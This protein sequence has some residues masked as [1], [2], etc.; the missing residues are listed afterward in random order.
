MWRAG[1]L[2]GELVVGRVVSWLRAFYCCCARVR[3]CV[4][5][6]LL[7]YLPACLLP[8]LRRCPLAC[9]PLNSLPESLSK[10]R[11]RIC[12]RERGAGGKR[13]AQAL[14]A[15]RIGGQQRIYT[16]VHLCINID[17]NMYRFTNIEISKCTNVSIYSLSRLI[18]TFHTI[19]TKDTRISRCLHILT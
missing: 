11:G 13:Q 9:L 14:G 8:L 15:A 19:R 1:C 16:R 4:L 18:C 10:E 12:M 3:A 5:A 6:C 2:A 7:G 17:L